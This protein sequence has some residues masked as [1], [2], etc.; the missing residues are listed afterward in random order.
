MDT[1]VMMTATTMT[2][3]DLLM[4]YA[5][6]T[7]SPGMQMLCAAHLEISGEASDTLALGEEIGGAFLKS[8]PTA[9]V[10]PLDFDALTA[11][12]DAQASEAE[13]IGSQPLPDAVKSAL[14]MR[15]DEIPWRFRLP[16]L[17]EYVLEGFDGERVSL[18]R[19][20]P[21]AAILQHTHEGDEATLILAGALK[22]GDR[23]LRRG[24]ISLAGPDHHHHPEIHG[25]EICY[26]LAV[27]Q[28]VRFTGTLG[29]AINLFLD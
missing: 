20:R 23:V 29:R 8:M 24:E 26:S 3:N 12:I 5:S 25:D 13:P 6:G 27:S 15:F 16:G 22:D 10:V 7:L 17:S 9:G 11:R 2:Q 14:G 21:G 4:G 19:A 1:A 18:M 28:G